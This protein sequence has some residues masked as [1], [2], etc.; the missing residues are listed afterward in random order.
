M[1]E[2]QVRRFY[3]PF[4]EGWPAAVA[5]VQFIISKLGRIFLLH[6]G[7]MAGLVMHIGGVDGQKWQCRVCVH[8]RPRPRGCVC[9]C[10]C[11][12]VGLLLGLRKPSGDGRRGDRVPREWGTQKWAQPQTP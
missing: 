7:D 1:A 12:C 11:V 3:G 8:A 10:V 5:S 9:V 6:A 4:V 2:S